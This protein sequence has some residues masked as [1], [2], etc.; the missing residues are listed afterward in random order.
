[1]SEPT[2]K[3]TTDAGE[4]KS[5]ADMMPIE[6]REVLSHVGKGDTESKIG[7]VMLL[8]HRD[9]QLSKQTIQEEIDVGGTDM[10]ALLLDLQ[11]AGMVTRK[12][13]GENEEQPVG[14]YEVSTYGERIVNSLHEAIQ[15]DFTSIIKSY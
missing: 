1:M 11:Q 10:D 5:Y 9:E 2:N 14:K 12:I 3:D 4:E 7:V 8:V 13:S 6:I 15:P